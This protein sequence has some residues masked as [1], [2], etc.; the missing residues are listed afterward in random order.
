[1]KIKAGKFERIP[2]RYSEELQRVVCWMLNQDYHVRP[3]VDD[4]MNLPQIS[5]R[6]REKKM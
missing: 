2:S 6:I 4:L 1:M 3:S 5:L